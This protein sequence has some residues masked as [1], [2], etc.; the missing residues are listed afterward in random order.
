LTLEYAM[1][2]I[3][4]GTSSD[5]KPANVEDNAIFI[6]TNTLKIYLKVSGTYLEMLQ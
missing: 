3:T 4:F 1:A 6:E 2:G 5:T